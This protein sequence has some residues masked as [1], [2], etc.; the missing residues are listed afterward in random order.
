MRLLRISCM[1]TFG[2]INLAG[3]TVLPAFSQS[4]VIAF[5]D[6]CTGLLYAMRG[7]GSGRIA[8]PLP[9]LPLPTDRYL[10]PMV[11]DVTT[12]GPTTVVYYVGIIGQ[13]FD[14]GLFAVQVDDVGGV[15]TSE[16]PVR[17]SF[18]EI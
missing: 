8:L 9:P 18:P 17:L 11:L 3:L 10:Q 4:G 13:P 7:D 12:S 6:A 1:I 16:T 2:L 15:L 5:Q 14:Q